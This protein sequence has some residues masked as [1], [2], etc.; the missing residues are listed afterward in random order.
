MSRNLITS[1]AKRAATTV[2]AAALVLTATAGVS[3]AAAP[4]ATTSGYNLV[5][6]NTVYDQ[7]SH[8]TPDANAS[9]HVGTLYKARNYFKCYT[10]GQTYHA[11]E[12]GRTS[13]IWLLTDDD[14]G[15]ANVYVTEVYLDTYGWLNDTS[16]LEKCK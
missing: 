4:S 11:V 14:N 12:N 16:L 8:K 7:W 2:A 13:N 9:S 10:Y 3:T 5:Y 1:A 6:L 15:N